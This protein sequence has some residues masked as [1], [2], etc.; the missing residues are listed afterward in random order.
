MNGL[1][2]SAEPLK[3]QAH[4]PQCGVF[5]A[6]VADLARDGEAMFV[7]F[8]GTAGFA[9]GVVCNSQ[10]APR[11]A[12]LSPIAQR[13]CDVQVLLIIFDGAAVLA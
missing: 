13:V 5:A 4:I 7:E 3:G 11:V 2:A 6:P 12:F 9:E 10:V 1:I 8:D